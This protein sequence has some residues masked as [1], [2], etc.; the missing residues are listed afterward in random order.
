MPEH[1]LIKQRFRCAIVVN[2]MNLSFSDLF[3]Y[4][5]SFLDHRAS[6]AELPISDEFEIMWKEALVKVSLHIYAWSNSIKTA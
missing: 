3:Q 1:L 2:K 5:F 4:T 6:T